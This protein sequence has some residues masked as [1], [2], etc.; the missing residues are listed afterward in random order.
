MIEVMM[1]K[2]LILITTI[3]LIDLNTW[4]VIQIQMNC[5]LFSYIYQCS[6]SKH[7]SAKK[8]EANVSFFSS[9][10]SL[11]FVAI[12]PAWKFMTGFAWNRLWQWPALQFH[13]ASKYCVVSWNFRNLKRKIEHP[14]IFAFVLSL[15]NQTFYLLKRIFNL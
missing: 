12:A 15:W 1:K 11:Q 5:V 4:T 13:F 14:N 3:V 9:S 10:I 7:S 6:W 2:M 8:R